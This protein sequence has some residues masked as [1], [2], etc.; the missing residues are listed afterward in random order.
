MEWDVNKVL[1]VLAGYPCYPVEIGG[2]GWGGKWTF[3]AAQGTN[4]KTPPAEFI[5]TLLVYLTLLSLIPEYQTIV[6]IG[7]ELIIKAILI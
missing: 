5:W 3:I 2:I 4:I 1:Q 7:E 6:N